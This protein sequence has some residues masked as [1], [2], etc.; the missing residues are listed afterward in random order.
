M[1]LWRRPLS[2]AMPAPE[3]EK[4]RESEE[5]TTESSYE[6]VEEEVE[7][8]PTVTLAPKAKGVAKKAAARPPVGVSSSDS[9]SPA[10][11]RPARGHVGDAI[12]QTP[13]ANHRNHRRTVSCPGEEALLQLLPRLPKGNL[14]PVTVVLV[15]ASTRAE[16]AAK[17]ARAN[18]STSGATSAGRKLHLASRV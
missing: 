12:D 2:S 14:L 5:E 1:F 18:N 15:K 6:E 8:K 3:G 11:T 10:P 7:A 13:H 9:V 4:E 17:R 16:K